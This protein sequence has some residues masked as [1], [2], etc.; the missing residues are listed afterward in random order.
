MFPFPVFCPGNSMPLPFSFTNTVNVGI[1]AQVTSN[2]ITPTGYDTPAEV[3]VT[4]GAQVSI[5][6]SA[7]T[8]LLTYIA[9]GE[10]IAVRGT[11]SGAWNTPVSFT[12]TIGG[13]STTWTVQTGAVTGG[14]WDTG[15]TAGSWNFTTPTFFS[16]VRVQLWAPGGGGGGGGT[17]FGTG[18]AWGGNGNGGGIAQ[19]DGGMYAT[20]GAGGG[21]GGP[22]S[23]AHQPG[24]AG[25]PGGHGDGYGGDAHTYAGGAGGGGGGAPSG[26]NPRAGGWGGAGGTG[27]YVIKTWSWGAIAPATAK[28]VLLQGPGSG[29]APG[30]VGGTASWGNTG[31]YGRAYID[32]G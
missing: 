22:G 18:G 26:G 9:P 32:W 14:N 2:T 1:N 19:F 13:R 16:W 8:G 21:G 15:W 5:N 20:G 17:Y 10:A 28:Y 30:T 25:A 23:A 6:G 31:G 4:S 3:S 27:G 29:G 11:S 12:I 24:D 7:W